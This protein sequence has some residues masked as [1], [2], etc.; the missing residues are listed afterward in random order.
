[1]KKIISILC[2]ITLILIA[3]TQIYA[4]KTEPEYN[5]EEVVVR[6]SDIDGKW[7]NIPNYRLGSSFS[8]YMDN[9]LDYIGEEPYWRL[10]KNC[11]YAIY[12]IEE[13]VTHYLI[14]NFPESASLGGGW[15]VSKIPSKYLFEKYVDIGT[16]MDVVKLIDQDTFNTFGRVEGWPCISFHHFNDGTYAQVTYEKDLSGKLVVKKIMYNIDSMHMVENLIDIDYQLIKNDNPNEEKEFLEKLKKLKEE[17]TSNNT[18]TTRTMQVKKMKPAKVTIKSAKRVKSRR[19]LVKFKKVKNAKK[20]QIQYATN[21]KFKK[22]R[23]KITKKNSYIIKKI[24]KKKIY[25]I[26]V[27]G[28]NGKKKGVWSKIKKVKLIS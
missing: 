26:R 6:V 5:N 21:K 18:S 9:I 4:Q 7:W 28:I 19:I 25:Y 17:T 2:V 16:S 24:S 13:K 22:A 11:Y 8:Y 23:I 3:K 15:Y 12:K 1:M 20:Y 14:L 27:R 10:G